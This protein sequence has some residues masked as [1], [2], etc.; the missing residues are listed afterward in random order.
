[1]AYPRNS[2]IIFPFYFSLIPKRRRQQR[3]M[4]WPLF[5][6]FFIKRGRRPRAH[7]GTHFFVARNDLEVPQRRKSR[8]EN[9]TQTKK[10]AT[11]ITNLG[12]TSLLIES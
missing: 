8:P 7:G 3:I 11:D 1:M 5:V 4:G 12:S 9:G 2:K 6:L 10:H